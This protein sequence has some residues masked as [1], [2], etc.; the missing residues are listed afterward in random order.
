MALMRVI[1]MESI[2]CSM[3]VELLGLLLLDLHFTLH[4]L[5][6]TSYLALAT[7]P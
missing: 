7:T 6:A 2:D 1:I 3:R 4:Y 5:L